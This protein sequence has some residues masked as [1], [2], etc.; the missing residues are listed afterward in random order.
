MVLVD[1]ITR[2]IPGV[3]GNS[4]SAQ[5]DSFFNG[6]LSPPQYTR[7]EE[8][9]NEK[10]PDVLISGHHE[11]IRAWQ[12]EQAIALTKLKRPDVWEEY[13]KNQDTSDV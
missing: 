7:P 9:E 4:E 11:N 2:L 8:F 10:V 1:A 13:C 6:L 12:K 5:L 3:L